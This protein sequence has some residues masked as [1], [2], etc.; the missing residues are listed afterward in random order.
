METENPKLRL[1]V[2]PQEAVLFRHLAE[3]VGARDVAHLLRA[4]ACWGLTYPS[5]ARRAVRATAPL[6][7]GAAAWRQKAGE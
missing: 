1:R 2:T 5:T 3:R 6:P 7:R 4:L